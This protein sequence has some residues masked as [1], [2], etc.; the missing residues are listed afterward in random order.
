MQVA[1]TNNRCFVVWSNELESRIDP[2]FYKPEFIEIDNAVKKLK[3]KTIKEISLDLKNGSTPRGGVFVKDGIPYFRSQDFN[4]FDFRIKQ[5]ITPEFHKKINRSAIKPNDVLLAVVG[6]TLG[7]IGYVP[8][9][10]TEG[11]INQNVAR[12]RVIDKEINPKYLAIFLSSNMGQ[13]LILRNATITTQAYLNNKQLGDIEIPILDLQSQNKI[14]KLVENA[15]DKKTDKEQKAENILN[16]IDD[17]ILGELGIKMPEAQDKDCFCIN[18]QEVDKSRLDCYYYQPKFKQGEKSLKKANCKVEPLKNYIT[19]IHYGAS[20]K[21]IYVDDGIPLLRIQ[22][23][24][25][26]RIILDD[27]VKIS[28][29]R[30][31]ELGNAFVSE[32]DLLISRS[33]SVGIVSV[34]PKEAEGF[35]FGSFMIK[36]CLN[37]KID[38]DFVSV[39]LNNKISQ[40]FIKR[41]KIGAIQGNITIETIENLQI[42]TPP[43]ATQNKL[44]VE[45]KERLA[46]AKKINAEAKNEVE[47]AK[48]EVEKIILGK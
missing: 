18:S 20:L 7:V 35:A 9:N 13:N 19:K 8:D 23:L 25:P 39:W 43:L 36:F 33:G 28:E 27:T 46:Q 22:N 12:I 48:R 30:R 1:N 15:Y 34:V 37:D 5:Y 38:K 3:H 6:A 31:K 26:N 16:S 24:K 2:Y 32:G 47:K 40:L 4:L 11:N 29:A 21:N 42:P 17:Y 14:I 10:I 45:V 44:A 41:E